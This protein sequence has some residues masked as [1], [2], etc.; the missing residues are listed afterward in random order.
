LKKVVVGT[1]IAVVLA[2]VGLVALRSRPEPPYDRAFDSRVPRPTYPTDGP[3]VL[4]DEGHL[5]VHTTTSGYKPL[6]DLL[7]NDGYRLRVSQ[8]PLTAPA[9]D[10]VQVLVL[11][12][13]RG[14]NDAN[15][16]GA[17]SEAE[18]AVIEAWVRAGGSLLLVSD[19]WPYG[20]ALSEARATSCSPR[21]TGCCGTIR[22]YADATR[23]SESEGC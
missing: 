11:A 18:T 19:H 13:A 12:L 20:P 14:A 6:A 16:D 8:E 17:Y 5:N 22:S 15:D 9:L 3:I 7:R 10:G 21:T 23:P 4:F 1:A 2:V